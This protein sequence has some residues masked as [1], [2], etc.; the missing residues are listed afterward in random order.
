[1]EIAQAEEQVCSEPEPRVRFRAFGDSSLDFQLMAWIDEPE[2]RG[3]VRDIL[4]TKIYKTFNEAN[5]EFPYPKRDLYI[6]EWPGK[7]Q[8]V[9]SDSSA[10]K[11]SS[12]D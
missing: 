1:M 8:D 10:N 6:R 4:L 9:A 12:E 3:R 2:L 7:F 11:V 5:I